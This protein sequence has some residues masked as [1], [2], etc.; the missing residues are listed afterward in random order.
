ML[1]QTAFA[2]DILYVFILWLTK[3]SVAYLFIRLTP[4]S[5]HVTAS[6]IVLGGSTISMII[7]ELLIAIRCDKSQPWII[8]GV[9]CSSLVRWLPNFFNGFATNTKLVSVPPLASYLGL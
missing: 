1:S 9:K 8:V 2:C 7:S 5:K 4:D 3:C 6:Y